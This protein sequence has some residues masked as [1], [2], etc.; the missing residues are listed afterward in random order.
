[1]EEVEAPTEHLTEEINEKAEELFKGKNLINVI[2]KCN[3]I[4]KVGI[5]AN[6]VNG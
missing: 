4:N 5:N 3:K 1:M 6:I 2:F